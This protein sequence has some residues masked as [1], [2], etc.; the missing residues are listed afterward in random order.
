M[1]FSLTLGPRRALTRS[2]ALG[3][4]SANLAMPGA[5]SLA[6]GR[7]VG[8]AQLALALVGMLISVGTGIGMVRWALANWSR[9]MSTADTDGFENMLEM[10]QH[11]RWPLV[12]ITLF[13]ISIG[14]AALTGWRLVS[15][16]PREGTPPLIQ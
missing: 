8:Y 2:E 1:K 14:W 3:C 16:A 4:F 6:A 9:L 5:G 11:V 7:A 15:Q 12:G 13:A 10:W